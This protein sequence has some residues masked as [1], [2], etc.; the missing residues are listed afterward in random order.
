MR[1]FQKTYSAGHKGR[2]WILE[3]RHQETVWQVS[4]HA[5]K[6]AAE[7]IAHN[8]KKLQSCQAGNLPLDPELMKWLQ[9]CPGRLR[10]RLGQIG[11]V[12]GCTQAGLRPLL[13]HLDGTP[14]MPGFRQV[15][16]ARSKTARYIAKRCGRV[17]RIFEGCRFNLWRDISPSRVLVYLDGLRRASGGIGAVTFNHYVSAVKEFSAWMVDDGRAIADPLHKRKLKR[18]D[19]KAERDSD[20]SNGRTRDRRALD[21]DE[22]R[23]LLDSTRRQPERFGMTGAERAI[24]YRLAIEVGLRAAE[25]RSLTR[26]S[27]DFF[28][29]PPTVTVLAGHSKHRRQ[30][31]VVL[32]PDT[33]AELREL[34]SAK[35]PEAPAFHV[36]QRTADMLRADL[37]AARRAWQKSA[38]APQDPGSRRKSTFLSDVDGS[39]RVL[40]FH[41]L[42][43]TTGSLLAASGVH[44][45]VAQKI[46][47]HSTIELTMN[48]YTHVYAGQEA[49]AVAALPDLA[50]PPEKA[51]RATGTDDIYT[52]QHT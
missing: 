24:L 2:T 7:G 41:A 29:V 20:R 6:E 21:P 22:S 10:A 50:A 38:A 3:F 27:F 28:A 18:L 11:L 4:A 9:E 46:M 1:I 33:A 40:D 48:F 37:A 8:I 49:D 26:R 30:D 19:V 42:R 31:E 36:P 32:R 13:E 14:A 47:R 15:L 44:P 16:T 12:D 5:E 43:H 17:R 25:L 45:K 52:S 39:G 51:A 34:L 23:W 35:T